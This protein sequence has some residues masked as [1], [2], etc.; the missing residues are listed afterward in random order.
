VLKIVG[1]NA[2]HKDDKSKLVTV[3]VTN[4]LVSHTNIKHK[5]N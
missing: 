2:K 1:L 5:K 4:D 3:L